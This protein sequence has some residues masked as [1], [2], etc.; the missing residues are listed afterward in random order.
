MTATTSTPSQLEV[1]SPKRIQVHKIK[2]KRLRQIGFLENLPKYS[3]VVSKCA[4]ES[5]VSRRTITRW[6]SED[7]WFCDRVAALMSDEEHGLIEL[8]HKQAQKGSTLAAIFLL[9]A[10]HGYQSKENAQ[11]NLNVYITSAQRDAVIRAKEIVD[12][13]KPETDRIVNKLIEEAKLRA[14]NAGIGD[15]D[16]DE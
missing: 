10:K 6:M 7:E 12:A 2:T 3:W 1:V 14:Q 11:L 9:K 13:S 15:V 8:L 5:S 16:A 4:K